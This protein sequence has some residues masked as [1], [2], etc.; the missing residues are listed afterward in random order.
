M[1]ILNVLQLKLR[2]ENTMDQQEMVVN[3]LKQEFQHLIASKQIPEVET[4]IENGNGVYFTSNCFRLKNINNHQYIINEYK[5][6]YKKFDPN[7]YLILNFE[8]TTE[9]TKE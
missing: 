1:D 7:N 4:R 9:E 2:N 5:I 8:H 3:Q 6:K